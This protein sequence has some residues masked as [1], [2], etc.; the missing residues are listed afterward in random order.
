MD[1]PH[2][3]DRTITIEAPPDLVFQY[4]TT[5]DRWAAWWGPGSTIDPRRGGRLFI[6]HPG[7]IEA[8]GEVLEVVVPERVV[9][10]YG[11]ASGDPMPLGASRVSIYLETVPRGTRVRLHHEFTDEAVR[12]HHIRGWRYQL[13]V[14]TNVVL[15]SLHADAAGVV[16]RWFTAWS[17]TDAAMRGRALADLAAPDV[18]MRDRFSAV[19]GIDE[20]SQHIGAAHKFMPGLRMEKS[21]AVRHC[22]GTVVV[23]WIA[24]GPDGQQ[25]AAG[26]NVFALG[27]D[28]RI[29]SVTGFW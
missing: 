25:R 1:F 22:Q 18:R 21:G 24:K 2:Y 6:R 28:G 23:D 4:F 14:F 20:L 12:D 8:G 27:A 9:F 11:F 15:D 5:D 7:G 13:S 10:T 3:L 17:E 16:D 29:E 19:E 26:T